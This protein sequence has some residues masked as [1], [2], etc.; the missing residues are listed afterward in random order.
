MK[1]AKAKAELPTI[2][3]PPETRFHLI[4]DVAYFREIHDA[5]TSGEA[6]DSARARCEVE[7]EIDAVIRKHTH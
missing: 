6:V 4:N 2:E 3:I 5:Q 7:A 1:K